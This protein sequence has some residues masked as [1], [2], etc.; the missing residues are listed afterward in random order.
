MLSFSWQ[1][2]S[3]L[4]KDMHMTSRRKSSRLL[5]LLLIIVMLILS[6][7][8]KTVYDD[9]DDD[10]SYQNNDDSSSF[11]NQIPKQQSLNANAAQDDYYLWNV[12]HYFGLK[13]DPLTQDDCTNWMD[14]WQ[15]GKAFWAIRIPDTAQALSDD[16][17]P[18]FMRLFSFA[19][20]ATGDLSKINLHIT[21]DHQSYL[22]SQLPAQAGEHWVALTGAGENA[23][24]CQ[25]DAPA[26]QW[27][28]NLSYLLDFGGG[29]EAGKDEITTEYYC[30]QG[31]EAPFFFPDSL[32]ARALLHLYSTQE[33]D[34]TCVGPLDVP[35][36]QEP[37]T[38]IVM[39]APIWRYVKPDVMK[40]RYHFVKPEEAYTIEW[41]LDSELS[42]GWKVLR[43]DQDG[44][45]SPEQ[46]VASPFILPESDAYLWAVGTMP[47]ST[48]SGHYVTS[49]TF[50]VT[51]PA[52]A[53][54]TQHELNT[55]VWVGDWTPPGPET[56][57]IYAPVILTR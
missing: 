6:L 43:G 3:T 10:S 15:S 30:Y 28:L 7:A 18:S 51:S 16:L 56:Y 8:C 47:D 14:L 33:D 53:S 45:Y 50:R 55:L 37:E 34:I 23:P 19:P 38:W 26:G 35:L 21:T 9:P 48:P 5:A 1:F 24:T 49:M 25:E 4:A 54:P 13:E 2:I 22:E 46:P 40:F 32:A 52:D 29:R 31:T 12:Q 20:G 42:A 57:T 17:N 39:N 11:V 44:P 41:Q 27:K 36:N